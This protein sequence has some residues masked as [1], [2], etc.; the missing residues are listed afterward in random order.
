MI[1]QVLYPRNMFDRYPTL[2]ALIDKMQRR[3]TKFIPEL[4]DLSYE[5]R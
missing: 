4:C 2:S 3:A 5:D 1:M